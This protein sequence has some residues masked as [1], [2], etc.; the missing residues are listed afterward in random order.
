MVL[1][2]GLWGVVLAVANKSGATWVVC[3]RCGRRGPSVAGCRYAQ[4]VETA[5]AKIRALESGW[6]IIKGKGQ[7]FPL[8]VCRKCKVEAK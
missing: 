3:R 1:S 7:E 5:T 6:K 4:V 8:L 2:Q